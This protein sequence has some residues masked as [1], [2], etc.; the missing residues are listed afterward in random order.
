MQGAENFQARGQV[1]QIYPSKEVPRD[2]AEAAGVPPGAVGSTGTSIGLANYPVFL[3]LSHENYNALY[4]L[5]LAAAINGYDLTITTLEEIT[6][7]ET[8]DIWYML[9]DWN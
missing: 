3:P 8:V 2:G 1:K 4:S 5:F 9:V 6:P 7:G